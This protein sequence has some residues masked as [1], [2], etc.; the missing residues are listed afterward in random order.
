[1]TDNTTP[2]DKPTTETPADETIDFRSII[3]T[4]ALAAIRDRNVAAAKGFFADIRA[5][6]A[7]GVPETEVAAET[8]ADISEKLGE[9]K[10]E[11]E[12]LPKVVTLQDILADA[13]AVPA[14]EASTEETAP[15]EEPTLLGIFNKIKAK[16]IDPVGTVKTLRDETLPKFRDDVDANIVKLEERLA[17]EEKNIATEVA[18]AASLEDLLDVFRAQAVNDK[19]LTSVITEI[20]KKLNNH[21]LRVFVRH[22]TVP[23]L[24]NLIAAQRLIRSSL[25][26]RLPHN[27]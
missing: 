16:V 13:E 19:S 25:A 3:N 23:T 9:P 20:E 18:F 5:K 2:A 26:A 8:V 4:E 21:R 11:T 24:K 7:A 17:T 12:D 10:I 15:V 6:L 27:D 22:N 1:M 14:E